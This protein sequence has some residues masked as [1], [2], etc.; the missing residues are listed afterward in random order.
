MTRELVTEVE[1]FPIAGVFTISRGSRTEARVVTCTLR[2]GETRGH[3]EC[4]PYPRYGETVESVVEEIEAARQD[5]V[6]GMGRA[7]LLTHMA[8]GAARNAIDCALWDL[9]AK[10]SG[11]RAAVLACSIPPRPVSTAYTIS[12]AAPEEMAAQA[13]AHAA[14]PL[15]KVKLGSD[16]DVAR[17]HAVAGAAPESRLIL[18]ANEGWTEQN[19][20]ENMLAAAEFHV[21]LIE[22]P[23]PAGKDEILRTIPHP[24]PICA[25]ESLHTAD[26]LAEIAGLYDFVNIKLDKTGGLTAALELRDRARDMGFGV[27]VGCM[28]GTSLAMAPAVLLAQGADF[29]DLDGPLLLAR[30]RPH[31]LSYSGSLVSPPHPQLW[32]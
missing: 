6:N 17:I 29:V 21:A 15:L 13:R 28:V 12:L 3:G 7:D 26:N 16:N 18:D 10:L 25:D 19:I 2:Q 30:D 24:V 22:Q 20:R 4:V 31:G 23:L 32:G 11:N 14:R 27:M 5:L 9:E 8:A 1:S